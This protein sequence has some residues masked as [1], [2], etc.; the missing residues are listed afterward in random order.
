MK[1]SSAIIIA[2]VLLGTPG[3]A[4]DSRDE[5]FVFKASRGD[6][7]FNH[8]AHQK[9][10]APQGC[11]PCHKTEKPSLYK[12]EKSFDPVI[13]HYFCKGCHREKGR[14]PMECHQCHKRNK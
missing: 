11:R 5:V 12:P 8:T 9:W 3:G 2:L 7:A 6:I 10:L 13:A 1:V 4:K 14:G